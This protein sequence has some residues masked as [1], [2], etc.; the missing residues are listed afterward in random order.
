MD[1]LLKIIQ[2]PSVDKYDA[3]KKPRGR[4]K[5][6]NGAADVSVRNQ[7]SI[8]GSEQPELAISNAQKEQVSD[9]KPVNL[10]PSNQ[11]VAT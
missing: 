6:Q 9:S 7:T 2:T 11:S 4:K 1:E 10:R 3:L 8:G 5:K